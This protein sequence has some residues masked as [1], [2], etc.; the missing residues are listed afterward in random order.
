MTTTDQLAR[1]LG[2]GWETMRYSQSP[3]PRTGSTMVAD[4]LNVG[5]VHRVELAHLAEEDVDVDDVS[6]V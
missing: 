3:I 4:L 5:S 6:E 1:V 2:P